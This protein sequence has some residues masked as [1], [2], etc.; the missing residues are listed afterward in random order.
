M[1][2]SYF[3]NVNQFYQLIFPTMVYERPHCN[4][5]LTTLD[6]IRCL[7]S[8]SLASVQGYL[9]NFCQL[10]SVTVTN[11]WVINLLKE[12][13]DFGSEF[14]RSWSMASWPFCSGCGQTL[15]IA[16]GC[17]RQKTPPPQQQES[18]IGSHSPHQDSPVGSSLQRFHSL[19]HNAVDLEPR[20]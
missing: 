10:L 4:R 17:E 2:E 13:S 19:P 5:T 8:S 20:Y 6:F 16:E 18:K 12:K 7:V 9:V 14:Q 15:F 3:D 1:I 11:I